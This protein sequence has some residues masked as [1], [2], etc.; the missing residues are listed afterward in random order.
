[1]KEPIKSI[2][3]TVLKPLGLSSSAG[4][5][6]LPAAP[7]TS[8]SI[9]P[10]SAC[11]RAIAVSSAAGSRTSAATGSTLPPACA[12]SSRRPTAAVSSLSCVRPQIA[13]CAPSAAKFEATP[14]LMPLPPPVTKTVL[15]LNS[16]RG[17]WC[18]TIMVFLWIQASEAGVVELDQ[19]R[20]EAAQQHVLRAGLGQLVAEEVVRR[21]QLAA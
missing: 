16:S 6:K 9:G 17:R 15:P 18:W 19:Q 11:V 12:F 7:A 2:S 5:R 13:T 10:T 20:L 4:H 1:W 14:R 3:M 8:T 21:G